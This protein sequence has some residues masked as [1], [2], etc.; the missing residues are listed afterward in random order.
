M[1]LCVLLPFLLCAAGV[2]GQDMQW[3]N[4]RRASRLRTMFAHCRVD[5]EARIAAIRTL[6][7]EKTE[8]DAARLV[9]Y[10]DRSERLADGIEVLDLCMSG[11]ELSDDYFV[12]VAKAFHVLDG[13]QEA[14]GF[15]T[16]I[17]APR[18]WT[19]ENEADLLASSETLIAV[20]D[21][22]DASAPA[23]EE[24]RLQQRVAVLEL[25]KELAEREAARKQL[26]LELAQLRLDALQTQRLIEKLE[27]AEE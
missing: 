26:E 12:F 14:P 7:R 1:R 22:R 19:P 5:M 27:S 18:P 4:P 8:R 15:V 3:L 9:W 24:E 10:R 20:Q 16:A 2:S 17:P 6:E 13:P 23:T 25:Q 21:A 11:N